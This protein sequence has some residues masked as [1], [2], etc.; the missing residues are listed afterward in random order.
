MRKLVY[1]L[2]AVVALLA[3]AALVLPSLIDW[4]AW[5]PE[6]SAKVKEVS[7]RTLEVR[8]DLNAGVLPS[9]H[10]AAHDVR[11]SNA[12][13]ARSADMATLRILKVNVRLAP[14]LKG[15]IEVAGIEL[16]Q[17]VI[18]LERLA[19][20]RMNWTLEAGGMAPGPGGEGTGDRAAA[21]FVEPDTAVRDG[22]E[23]VRERAVPGLAA[24]GSVRAFRLDN[25]S[26]RDG[27]INY[28]DS[29]KG[30][31]ESIRNLS[32]DGALDS[33][34]GPAKLKGGMTVRGL[35]LAFD[36]S[37][38]RHVEGTPLAFALDLG[39]RGVSTVSV[40]GTVTGLGDAPRLRA[41]VRGGGRSLRDLVGALPGSAAPRA[42]DHP[43]ALAASL[44][45]T[46][47]AITLE[48]LTVEL[49]GA[50]A[51]GSAKVTT[52]R[53]IRAD[54][55]LEADRIDADAFLPAAAPGSRTG[56]APG[57]AGK[58]MVAAGGPGVRGRASRRRGGAGGRRQGGGGGRW[59]RGVRGRASRRRG[60]SGRC[61]QGGGRDGQGRGGIRGPASRRHRRA[62]RPRG[63]GN[64][65]EGQADP[66]GAPRCFARRRSTV[67]RQV[68]RTVAGWRD[69][70]RNG[71]RLRRR[72]NVALRR[73][74]VLPCG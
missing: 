7:G 23:G 6:L 33:L 1:G 31:V 64:R 45:A 40:K 69:V 46:P 4:N 14:L 66:G 20:G 70:R 12:P 50:R 63:R 48:D 43:F 22:P 9:L 19:G 68:F 72:R 35:Q 42:P 44:S 62:G 52:G 24:A 26:I 18:E 71:H 25:L 13:G 34:T 38:G 8:G 30:T 3:A 32:A 5:K 59:D 60:G 37:I 10:L 65:A 28:R 57:D 53:V 73:Q 2:L 55:A 54:V 29:A 47:E 41:D 39:T 16:V 67:A 15:R 21:G 56:D 61:R 11:L 36:G 27:T 17:P 49:G 58:D 74:A 51:R